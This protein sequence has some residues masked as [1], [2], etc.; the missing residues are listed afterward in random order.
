MLDEGISI[1]LPP[2]W[3]GEP[4]EAEEV[5]PINHLVGPNGSGKSR[6]ATELLRHLERRSSKARLLSTD[7]LREM[8]NPGTLGD[9]FGDFFRAG[10]PQNQFDQLLNAGREGSGIDALPLLVDRLDLR[11]RIEATLRTL[12]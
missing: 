9:F 5:G 11:I 12:I 2:P 8:S 3:A 7:R 6:F 10:I 1:N 4:F